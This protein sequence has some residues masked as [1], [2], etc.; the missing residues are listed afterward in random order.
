MLGSVPDA[1]SL[2][3]FVSEIRAIWFNRVSFEVLLQKCRGIESVLLTFLGRQNFLNTDLI[4]KVLGF[5]ISQ[6]RSLLII[7]QMCANSIR[8]CHNEAAIVHVQPI[9]PT[10]KLVRGVP[11]E[12]AV[13]LSAKVGFVKAGHERQLHNQRTNQAN[14]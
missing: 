11:R 8:H 13:G 5:Q 7:G 6:M 4:D 14:F 9:A 12:R 1:L 10:N 2:N 3:Q